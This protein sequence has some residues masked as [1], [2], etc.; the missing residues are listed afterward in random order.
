VHVPV[1]LIDLA[2]LQAKHLL[3]LNDFGFLPHGILLELD[4]KDFI[5]LLIFPE[6][7]LCFLGSLDPMAND[8]TR[9]AASGHRNLIKFS[10][11]ALWGV[12]TRALQQLHTAS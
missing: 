9:D 3:E 11:A 5:L 6:A 2:L 1:P 10:T 8:H 4:Q 7:L 12:F